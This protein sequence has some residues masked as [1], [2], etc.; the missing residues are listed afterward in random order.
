MRDARSIA[1]LAAAI[2]L[3]LGGQ[4]AYGQT[5]TI[6]VSNAWAR[7]AA[8]AHGDKGAMGKDMAGMGKDMAGM[9]KDRGAMESMGQSGGRGGMA[10]MAGGGAT[11]AVYLTLDNAGPQADAL[12]SASSEVAR[13]T[14]LHEVKQDGGVMKM[15]PVE[16]IPVPAGGKVDLKPGGYH[17]MLIGLTRD[18][19]PGDTVPV[20]LRFERGGEMRVEAAVK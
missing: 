8:M 4:A 3:C 18:L 6:K 16:K 12:V 7:R 15:R 2:A 19:K 5:A 17:V 1:A 9:G 11:S 14:E 13:T 10:S 20:T